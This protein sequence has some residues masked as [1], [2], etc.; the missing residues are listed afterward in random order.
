M[1]MPDSGVA[2]MV[3]CR[4]CPLRRRDAFAPNTEQEIDF[5]QSLK[6][7]DFV[8]PAQSK[9]IREGLK[10]AHLYTLLEGWAFRFR[11]LSSG[12]R[13]ILN[14][15]LPGDFIG[16]QQ[17]MNTES[18][19][20]VEVL[21]DSR[22]CRFPAERIWDVFTHQPSLA[23]DITWLAA[24]E[25]LIVDENLVSVGRRSAEQRVGM[26]LVHLFKRAEAVG[27][28]ADDGSVPFPVSQQ[29]MAD[30]L[31]LSLVHTNRTLQS[32][33]KSG[34]FR[35]GEG[36]LAIDKQEALTRI[37]DYYSLPQRGR[38]LI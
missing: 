6:I 13:Q 35:L 9:L 17:K 32:L 1:Q 14:F 24:N 34:A 36:R 26:L 25:E 38:P 2:A 16:L 20:G 5:I 28:R 27:M 7:D 8:L 10:T 31:G 12:G 18:S 3:P 11:T 23:Y 19:F 30:A 33:R 37:A 15:L 29:H 21:T 22:F 4:L